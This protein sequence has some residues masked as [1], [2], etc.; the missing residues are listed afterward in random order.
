MQ[1]NIE[2]PI[3]QSVQRL[4]VQPEDYNGIQAVRIIFPDKDSFVMAQ[5]QGEWNVLDEVDINPQLIDA[6]AKEL[7]THARYT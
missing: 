4:S 5:Q 2:N 1:I 7:K 3:D 6:I